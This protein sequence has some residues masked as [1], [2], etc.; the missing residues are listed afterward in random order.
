MKNSQYYK[1]IITTARNNWIGLLAVRKHI[2]P[3][4]LGAI[5]LFLWNFLKICS[6]I[7]DYYILFWHVFFE[8]IKSTHNMGIVVHIVINMKW[9]FMN[10]NSYI[11]WWYSQIFTYISCRIIVNLNNLIYI[12][13]EIGK[14]N[15]VSE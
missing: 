13:Y 8:F 5:C 3:I 10:I 4:F 2:A 15:S 9:L 1:R 7:M 12:S 6:W 11:I 14:M